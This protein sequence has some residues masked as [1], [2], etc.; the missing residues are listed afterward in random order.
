MSGISR[1]NEWRPETLD[2]WLREAADLPDDPYETLWSN[3]RPR[4]DESAL[5]PAA[6]TH[7]HTAASVKPRP[8]TVRQVQRPAGDER[9]GRIDRESKFGTMLDGMDSER[10][11]GL[12]NGAFKG[13]VRD[14]AR[15]TFPA[16]GLIRE[17]LLRHLEFVSQVTE[18]V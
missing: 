16:K 8:G 4:G 2:D 13:L 18:C 14:V 12:I 5:S 11:A 10:F 15:M 1:L 6:A 17:R 9:Q 3:G 7:E